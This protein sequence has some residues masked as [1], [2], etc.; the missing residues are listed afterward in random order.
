VPGVGCRRELWTPRIWPGALL[1]DGEIGGTW[2]RAGA[3]LTVRRWRPLSGA[4]RDAVEA[5]APSLPL[6]GIRGQVVVRWDEGK[7]ALPAP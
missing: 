2:R 6:T 4:G 5:E 1:V 3:V 7:A